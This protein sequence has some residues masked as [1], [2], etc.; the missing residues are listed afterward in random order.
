MSILDIK[1][2]QFKYVLSTL[3]LVLPNPSIFSIRATQVTSGF[4]YIIGLGVPKDTFIKFFGFRVCTH[5][6][7]QPNRLLYLFL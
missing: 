4:A 5:F 6:S 3:I 1:Y 7:S 2:I